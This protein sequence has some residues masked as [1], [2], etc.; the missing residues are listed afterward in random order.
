M[1]NARACFRKLFRHNEDNAEPLR[2]RSCLPMWIA[3]HTLSYEPDNS[4]LLLKKSSMKFSQH[5]NYSTI[6]SR[7]SNFLKIS[8]PFRKVKK[9]LKTVDYT[10][11]NAVEQTCIMNKLKITTRYVQKDK[12]KFSLATHKRYNS[13]SPSSKT[14]TISS[15]LD[16]ENLKIKPIHLFKNSLLKRIVNPKYIAVK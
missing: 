14:K 8:T 9:P 1:C 16:I 11:K 3:K 2:D 10:D 15:A 7:P 6:Y 5:T 12:C 13:Y 4:C